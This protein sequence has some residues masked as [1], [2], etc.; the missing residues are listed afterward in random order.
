MSPL[1][2]ELRTALSSRTDSIELSPDFFPGVERRARRMHRNRVAATVAGSALAVSALGVGGPMVASTLTRDAA[3]PMATS[4]PTQ[5]VEQGP[6]Y[7][8]D[9]ADPWAYRGDPAVLGDDNGAVYAREVETVHPELTA[10]EWSFAPLYGLQDEPSGSDVL[11]FLVNA[12][13]GRPFWGLARSSE[14]GPELAGV[15]ELI[16]GQTALKVG[17]PADEAGR[18]LVVTAPVPGITVE[19]ASEL[20]T[21]W[22]PMSLR[23][24]GVAITAR[25]GAPEADRFRVLD[26]SGGVVVEG[27]AAPQLAFDEPV[28]TGDDVGAGGDEVPGDDVP[29]PTNVVDWPTRGGAAAELVETALSRY[30]DEVGVSR[31]QVG[32][33]LLYAYQLPGTSRGHLLLQVWSGGDARTFGVQFDGQTG[34]VTATVLGGFTAPGPAALAVLFPGSGSGVAQ[35]LLVVPEPR[36]GQVLYSPD[37][38]AEPQ[39]VPDQGTEAAVVITRTAGTSGDR[40]LVLDGNG[41]FDQPIYRGTVDDLLA[42]MR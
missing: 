13:D 15:R 28:G 14:S 9:P 25:A 42:T 29:A 4:G 21:G 27:R 12:A 3:P 5:V 34:A 10:G 30:A 33:R 16:P 2:D 32:S 40:L 1:S 18:L 11:V 38:A 36:T 8:L 7:A 20:T 6:S 31:D 37:G 22:T 17:L 35:Q 24:D 39:P 19:Y 23:E 26:P 41:D